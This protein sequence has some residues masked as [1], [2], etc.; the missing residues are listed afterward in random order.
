MARID[1][2]AQRENLAALDEEFQQAVQELEE[3]MDVSALELETIEFALRK[4]DINVSTI[5]LA[6]AWT[7]LRVGIDEPSVP[8]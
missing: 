8:G 3:T 1:L 5:G 4:S 7:P 6:W 2:D